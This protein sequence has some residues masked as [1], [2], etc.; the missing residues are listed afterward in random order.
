MAIADTFDAITTDR[1]YRAGVPIDKAL[2][3]LYEVKGSQL[4]EK[5]V[6]IFR[7]LIKT[8]K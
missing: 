5:L 7:K 1:P 4:D 6:E 3:I 8:N 2:D